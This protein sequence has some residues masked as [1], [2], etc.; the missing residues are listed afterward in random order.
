[1]SGHTPRSLTLHGAVP[2]EARKVWARLD[3]SRGHAGFCLWPVVPLSRTG[4]VPLAD[5]PGCFQRPVCKHSHRL[6][7]Q[8]VHSAPKPGRKALWGG[9]VS[10]PLPLT[11]GSSLGVHTP[12]P[13]QNHM[14]SSVPATAPSES[15]A[16]PDSVRQLHGSPS[17]NACVGMGRADLGAQWDSCSPCCPEAAGPK[18]ARAFTPLLPRCL[19]QSALAP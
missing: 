12:R 5:L 8:A 9:P 17:S 14:P 13:R 4:P 15:S 10:G 3:E 6:F 1:M 11:L 18:R 2:L 7:P 19:C 16:E